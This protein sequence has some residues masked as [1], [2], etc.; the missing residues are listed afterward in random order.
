MSQAQPAS[1]RPLT[2]LLIAQ[3]LGA[4]NDNAL[5][6]IV[7]LLGFAAVAGGGEQA[8]QTA[9]TVAFVTLT[10]PLML[11]SLPS[12]WL[13][14]RVGKRGIVVAT[15]GLEVV[16]MAAGTAALLLQPHGWLPLVVLAGMGAQ[17]ALFSPA[18]YGI[19]PQLVSHERL[20]VA[21]GRLEAAS[22]LAIILGTVAGGAL[23]EMAGAQVWVAGLVLLLLSVVGFV[24]AIAVPKV[25]PT[26]SAESFTK[27]FGGAWRPCAA[28]APCGWPRSARSCSG[29]SPACSA[30]TC[31]STARRYWPSPTA[32]RGCRT[33][34]SRS[35]SAPAR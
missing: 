31:S 20:A 19:L 29:A 13:A 16:L 30:R 27:T 2:G 33:R 14:D 7:A 21:N 12:M 5:K 25:P 23:L 26:G 8:E 32:T 18:K 15:K 34:C 6:M 24:A 3:F 11:F 22:F 9:T 28:T 10:L 17:S 4:F 1:S 35:A